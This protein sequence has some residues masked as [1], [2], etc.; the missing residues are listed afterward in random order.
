MNVSAR[1]DFGE[2]VLTVNQSFH[3]WNKQRSVTPWP[4]VSLLLQV[5]GA[6]FVKR[7]MKEMAS[8]AM[9]MCSWDCPFSLK[10][11]DF[12]SG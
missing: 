2:T 4:P 7:A 11:L 12:T 8:R 3:A 5:F 1:K 10:R 9:E 6:A